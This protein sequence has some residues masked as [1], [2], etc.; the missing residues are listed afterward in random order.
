MRLWE[1]L[2]VAAIVVA[3]LWPALEG[4]RLYRGIMAVALIATATIQWGAEGFRWQLWGLYGVALGMAL[5]DLLA[6]ERRL[7]SYQRV[8][9]VILGLVGVI[10]VMAPA[11]ALPVVELPPPTGPYQVA[12]DSLQIHSSDRLEDY[13][14]DPG[15]FRRLMVQFWYPGVVDEDAAPLSPWINDLEVVGPAISETLGLPGFFLDHTRYTP[16]HSYAEAAHYQGKLPVIIY[17]HGWRLFRNAAIHQ[18]ESLA[19]HGFLVVAID[20]SYGSVATVFPDGEVARLYPGALPDPDEAGDEVFDQAAIKLLQTYSEDILMVIDGLGE[21][22]VG[23][24][25]AVAA[26]ADMDRVGIYGHSLGGGAA[27]RTCLVEKACR[28]V[29]ALDGW[30]EPIVP[31]ELSRELDVPSLFIRSD[32][33]RDMENDQVLRGLVERSSRRTYWIGIEDTVHSD[34]TLAPAISHVAGWLG[35]RGSMPAAQVF[36]I[37]DRYLVSF[38]DRHLLGQGGRD[39]TEAPPSGVV[40]ELIP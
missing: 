20:H 32:P 8:R 33:W 24:F 1:L 21:G 27:V 3:V 19:S 40:F 34:L 23:P 7:E 31:S 2:L 17:S 4:R 29:A 25:G 11:W 26:V 12:T 10:L 22:V 13:G 28:A 14:S 18:M 36:A 38:F 16:S 5:G 39:L 9:R 35:L 15:A 37:V 30:I 6:R